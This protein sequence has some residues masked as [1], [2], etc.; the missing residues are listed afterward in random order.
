MCFKRHYQEN[1]G[2]PLWSSE[3]RIWHC[4]YSQ[5]WVAAV[6]WVQSL[7]QKLG[8]CS[9]KKKEKKRKWKDNSQK[10]GKYLQIVYMIR[11]ISIIHKKLTQLK[12]EQKISRGIS[13]KMCKWLISTWCS[14][15]LVIRKKQ[16]KSTV[17]HYFISARMARFRKAESKC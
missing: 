14:T 17:K 16:I 7:D 15:S 8:E 10:I 11:D 13:P 1:G 9:Q 3:L 5:P 12:T 6:V 2:V 4:H